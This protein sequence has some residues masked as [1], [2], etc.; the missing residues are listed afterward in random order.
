MSESDVKHL[1]GQILEGVLDSAIPEYVKGADHDYFIRKSGLA[2]YTTVNDVAAMIRDAM[3]GQNID[4][5][6]VFTLYQ[7]TNSPTVPPAK[8]VPGV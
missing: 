2:N 6:R 7:R 4:Y 5:Y 3:T 8:P 1:I